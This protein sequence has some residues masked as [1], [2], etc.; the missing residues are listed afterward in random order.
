MT[1]TTFQRPYRP[2]TMRLLNGMGRLLRG[3]GFR[4]P[5]RPS[6]ILEAAS[7]ETGLS[8][9]GDESFRPG[10]ERLVQSFEEDSRL[11][12]LGRLFMRYG[13]VQYAKTRLLV[14]YWVTR[15]PGILKEE[16]RRP[17]FVVGFPR[18]GTTLLH[19]LLCQ[20]RRGRPLLLWEALEPAPSPDFIPG[21]FD[22]RIGRAQ[23]FVTLTMRYG[24]PDMASIHPLDA[25]GPEECIFLLLNTF[26][27]PAYLIF[28]DVRGYLDWLRERGD[29]ERLPVYQEYRRQ[30]Q[31][32]QW[33]RP[34]RHWVLKSPMHL[35]GLDTLLRLFP[36]AHV[37][38][39]HRDMN[40]VIPSG[41]SLKAVSRGMYSDHVDCERIGTEI[42]DY[43]HDFFQPMVK[44]RAA[45]PGRVFDLHY[46]DLVRD[47]VAAVRAAYE[48]FRIEP[49]DGMEERM[50]QWLARNPANKHG[51]HHYSLAQFGLTVEDIKKWFGAYHE[52]FGVAPETATA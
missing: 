39:T 43:Y 22:P 1:A 47:P 29:K 28:T 34:G 41:F 45:H 50:R 25:E 35:W 26:R 2:L 27:N 48:F 19:K 4:R 51:V 42:Q 23:Q 31:L 36:D 16:V 5:L 24:A 14:Q 15:E 46:R 12:P 20:D 30:L 13:L 38:Q 21:A 33:R 52:Q 17:V 6:A 8:D 10:L 40:K 37:I 11:T 7:R 9:W 3:V 49:N 18:T 44:A 32:L